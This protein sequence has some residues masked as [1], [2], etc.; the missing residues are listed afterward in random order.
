MKK[1]I[2]ILLIMFSSLAYGEVTLQDCLD[3]ASLQADNRTPLQP[4]SECPD[5]I[6]AN[7][8]H[9]TATTADNRWKAFGISQMMY[10]DAFDAAGNFSD[11]VLL[12]GS[13]TE[14]ASIKK[15]FIDTVYK[16]L[17]V[18]QL[19]NDQY[20]LMVYNLL[21]IGNVSPLKVMRSPTFAAVTSVRM[22]DSQQI[23]VVSA[24]GT[25]LVMAD[26]ESREELSTEKALTI[27]PK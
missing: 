18:V 11:R 17:F 1:I 25:Y 16:K 15:I 4:L 21:F 8:S 24:S 23:E 13:E 26:G 27:A 9:V 5:L 19:K 6:K 3:D 10:L 14:L 2:F 22:E 7:P 20:E 12:S